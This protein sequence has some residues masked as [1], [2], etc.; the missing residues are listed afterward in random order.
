MSVQRR[1]EAMGFSPVSSS[2]LLC[3]SQ[4]TRAARLGVS[5][6]ENKLTP[7]IGMRLSNQL[8]REREWEVLET[9]DDVIDGQHVQV[10]VVAPGCSSGA[11]I[12]GQRAQARSADGTRNSAGIEPGSLNQPGV[13]PLPPRSKR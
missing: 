10:K 1:V 11:L 7:H 13:S 6:S 2:P 3:G 12:W 5:M 8:L 4:W 9:R